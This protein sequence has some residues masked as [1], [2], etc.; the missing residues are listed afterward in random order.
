MKTKNKESLLAK[1]KY[2]ELNMLVNV[3]GNNILLIFSIKEN[4]NFVKSHLKMYAYYDSLYLK[5]WIYCKK[6]FK[7]KNIWIKMDAVQK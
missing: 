6:E 5:K 2:I 7:K 1:I 4:L 3:V